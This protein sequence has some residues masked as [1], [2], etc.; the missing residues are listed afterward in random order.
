MN[1]S[2]ALELRFPSS[3]TCSELF[4][5]LLALLDDLQP[6]AIDEGTYAPGAEDAPP[7]SWR[8]YFGSPDT[9]D[10]AASVLADAFRA[11]GVAIGVIDVEDAGWIERSQAMLTAVRVDRVVV[12]PPWDPPSN[13]E[14][15]VVVIRPSRG[16]GTGHHASTRLCLRALQRFDLAGRTVIDV[17]TGSGVLAIA[18]VRLGAAHAIAIDCDP[19][20]LA[21]A[22][23]NAELNAVSDR[24]A[25]AAADL[26][27]VDR[28]R[29]APADLVLANLTAAVLERHAD[30]L[31]RLVAPGGSLIASGVMPDQDAS[32]AA[33]F[34]NDPA[35]TLTVARID[36]QDDWVALTLR[37]GRVTPR[38]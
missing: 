11:A 22:R 6:V 33:A 29:L 12:A 15:V 20:A 37:R 1:T 5:R 17:G 36:R 7:Q 34:Q 10:H 13:A 18:A 2:P 31:G 24:V 26:A 27:D 30:T 9:R 16:F 32:V 21:S 8:V 25:L 14:A 3:T 35:L 23:E 38:S 4:D 28:L 19:D